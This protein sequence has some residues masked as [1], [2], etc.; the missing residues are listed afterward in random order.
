ME[1]FKVEPTKSDNELMNNLCHRVRLDPL[2]SDGSEKFVHFLQTKQ[3]RLNS[4]ILDWCRQQYGKFG[5]DWGVQYHEG[6][7]TIFLKSESDIVTFKLKW[8]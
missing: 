1:Y 2:D 5:Y 4:K 6:R 7:I 3:P 8:Q